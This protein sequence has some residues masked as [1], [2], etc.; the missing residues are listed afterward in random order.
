MQVSKLVCVCVLM[1][2]ELL[3]AGLFVVLD[4]IFDGLYWLYSSCILVVCLNGVDGLDL[5]NFTLGR[6]Y[7]TVIDLCIVQTLCF[8]IVVNVFF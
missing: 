2:N 4:Y 5:M 3:G 8:S 6:S 7:I 1:I